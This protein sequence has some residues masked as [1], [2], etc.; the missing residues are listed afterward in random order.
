MQ[1]RIDQ[2][3]QA[4][5]R[6]QMEGGNGN[7]VIFQTD[8]RKNYYVQVAGQNNDPALYLEA[9]SNECLEPEHRLSRAQE[10]LLKFMDWEPPN[11]S[12]INYYRHEDAATDVERRQVANLIYTVLSKVY[13][14]RPD[15]EI[16]IHLVLE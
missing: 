9:V 1:K 11:A 3:E 16:D 15:Q 6:I 4:L 2:I 14:Y 5:K 10:D 12:Q 7:F 8:F 13:G